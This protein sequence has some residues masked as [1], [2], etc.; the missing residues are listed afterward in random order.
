M[1]R[2][3]FA[4]KD[5]NGA[6]KLL[7]AERLL[8]A[9]EE[10]GLLLKSFAMASRGNVAYERAA[11]MMLLGGAQEERHADEVLAIVDGAHKN[12]A[13][14][15]HALGMLTARLEHVLEITNSTRARIGSMQ[16]L[17]YIGMAFFF[18]LFSS[19][20]ASIISSTVGAVSASAPI[21]SGRLIVM[22]LAYSGIILFL[23][24]SFAHPERSAMGNALRSLPY[25]AVSIIT[26]IGSGLLIS[27]LL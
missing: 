9:Y 2:R 17:T 19:I 23:S 1:A 4:G 13:S 7:T 10:S 20:S 26:S 5:D 24:A 16:M 12:G 15:K 18:P 27:N 3:L 21:A 22:A 8:N 11:K 25:F 6:Q 14:A